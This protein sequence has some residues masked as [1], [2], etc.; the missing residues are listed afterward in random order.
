M[1]ELE[2]V[3]AGRD[4]LNCGQQRGMAA[5]TLTTEAVG[6]G[7]FDGNSAV[8]VR[9]VSD[10]V[11]LL[12]NAEIGGGPPAVGGRAATDA[13]TLRAGKRKGYFAAPDRRREHVSRLQ[14]FAEAER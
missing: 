9:N 2:E 12:G 4:V 11:G 8:F 6:D 14:P 7:L 13:A 5:R 10:H 3:G 1:D